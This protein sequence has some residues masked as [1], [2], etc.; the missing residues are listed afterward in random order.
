MKDNKL[1]AAL[2][3]VLIGIIWFVADK[4]MKRDKLVKFHVKQAIVLFVT[5]IV[6][7]ILATAIPIIGG[8]IYLL[9]ELFILVLW[10]LGIVSALGGKREELPVIG[11]FGELLKF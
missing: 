2:S 7:S 10:I 4:K 3:Y 6:L 5:S 8:L 11:R 1:C 9:V